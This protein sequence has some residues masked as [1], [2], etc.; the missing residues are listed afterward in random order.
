M[1]APDAILYTVIVVNYNGLKHLAGCLQALSE[2]TFP[3][4]QYEVLIVDN[5]SVD[6]S[7][8]WLQQ[9]YS[10]YRLLRLPTNVGFAQANNIA[11]SHAR[12]D[13]LVLLNHDT[14]ADPFWLEEMHNARI[15]TGSAVAAKLVLSHEPTR[16][17]S[18]GLM[19]LRD[20]RG[21]DRGF[22]QPDHGQYERTEPVFM[23]CGAAIMLPK[24]RAGQLLPA[25]YFLYYEDL[26]T[27]WAMQKQ[28]RPVVYAPRALVRHAVGATQREATPYFHFL[29]LRNRWLTAAIHGGAFLTAAITLIILVKCLLAI[30]VKRDRA[31]SLAL[32]RVL[33]SG[34]WLYLRHLWRTHVIGAAS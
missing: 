4:F 22:L 21:A 12:A 19:L 18:A 27:G 31:L 15:R 3:A 26:A 24:P 2:Q 5:A 8:A 17:N 34:A 20:G 1:T 11:A 29:T 13:W 10:R 28:G 16:L 30:V 32:L 14:L 25:D 9:H 23:G 6:G 7:V 33:P